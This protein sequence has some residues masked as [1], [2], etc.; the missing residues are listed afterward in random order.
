M[1][2]LR[3]NDICLFVKLHSQARQLS[4]KMEDNNNN[5]MTFSENNTDIEDDVSTEVEDSM[6]TVKS[7]KSVDMKKRKRRKL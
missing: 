4:T 2:K 5:S 1:G 7:G 6:A 3:A